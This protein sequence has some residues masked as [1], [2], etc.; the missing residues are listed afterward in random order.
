MQLLLQL[1]SIHTNY[2]AECTEK[3]FGSNTADNTLLRFSL[4]WLKLYIVQSN[5][6]G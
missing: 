6:E 4:F 2:Q 5:E 3:W 1:I